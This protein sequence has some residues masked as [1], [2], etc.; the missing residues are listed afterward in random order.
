MK[1]VKK[2]VDEK[3]EKTPKLAKSQTKSLGKSETKSLKSADTKKLSVSQTRAKKIKH[4]Y[5]VKDA[6]NALLLKLKDGEV[7]IEMLPDIAPNHVARIKELV[8][9]GFYNGLFTIFL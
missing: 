8:R 3:K 4:S 9:A 7:V 5:K 1:A 2:I 6:E